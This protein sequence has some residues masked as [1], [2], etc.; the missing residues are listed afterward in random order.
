MNKQIFN[1]NQL[2][3]AVGV[4]FPNDMEFIMPGIAHDSRLAMDAQPGLVTTSNAGIPSMLTNYIDPKVI[5]ILVAPMKAAEIIG[6]T[7]K[8]DWTTDTAT[9]PVVEYTGEVSAYGDYSNNGSAGANTAFPQR[10]SFHYQT[11]TQW[12]E[13]ELERAGLAKIDWASRVNI[14]SILVL[15][16]YQNLSYFFG[17]ANLQN[18]GL[19]NDP[20]LTTP[21]APASKAAGGV[22]WAAGTAL[23]IY[24]DVL[25]M[26]TQLQSQSNGLVTMDEK[27]TLALSPTLAVNLNKVTQYNVAV[28]TTIK[29]NFPNL[30]IVTAPEYATQG[31][32]LVQMIVDS[33]DGQDTATCAFTE[34]LRAHAVER[35][36]SSFL[37][38]KS[39][40][41]WGTIIF[42]PFL[43]SQLL[44][45]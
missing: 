19:L 21:I 44:G 32:Q 15:N 7:K 12:G 8:G 20:R 41:T 34:K 25:N 42:R 1:R 43:I 40:G 2:A 28:R 23:E 10:Q 11:L 9:F 24:Q 45:A 26:F 37:Q 17:I 27:M 18:Y 16:K 38:K 6:E 3:S 5:E 29:E 35:K 14:A 13:R 39:Q 22:T 33:M 30:R 4:I 36:T 31:G